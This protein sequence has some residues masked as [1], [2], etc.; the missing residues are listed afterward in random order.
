M[1]S[2]ASGKPLASLADMRDRTVH[3]ALDDEVEE[4]QPVAFVQHVDVLVADLEKHRDNFW[5]T[6]RSLVDALPK[7]ASDRVAHHVEVMIEAARAS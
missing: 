4:L 6:Y 3:A 2:D 5:A 7:D 1:K